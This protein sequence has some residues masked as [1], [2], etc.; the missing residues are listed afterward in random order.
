MP[1]AGDVGRFAYCPQ[2][3]QLSRKGHDSHDEVTRAGIQA[4]QSLGKGQASAERVGRDHR[5]ALTWSTRILAVAASATMLTLEVLFLRAHPLLWIFLAT[6]LVLLSTSVGLL[7]IGLDAERRY[8][9]Q[10]RRLGLVPGR[11]MDSDLAGQGDTL[12]DPEWGV[13][14]RPDYVLETDSGL[15]PVEVKTGRTPERPHESHRLQLACYL[16]LVEATHRQAPAYGLLA[17]PEGVFRVAWDADTKSRLR[18]ILADIA[19]AEETGVAK[20]NH[21]IRGRCRGCSKREFCDERLV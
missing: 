15:V 4:H 18:D 16:R 1:S 6:T 13:S 10:Q 14:G 3:W 21:D 5:D 8:Q 11:L 9:S 20:R 12:H 7:V 17:Y 19:T 2:S